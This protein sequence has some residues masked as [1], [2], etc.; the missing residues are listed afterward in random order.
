[1]RARE[2]GGPE[3]PGADRAGECEGTLAAWEIEWLAQGYSGELTFY[4]V[5]Q[6]LK[7]VAAAVAK[8]MGKLAGAEAETTIEPEADLL[9]IIAYDLFG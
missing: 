2:Q 8:P 3:T 5:G 7:M 6:F 9:P 1:M 4:G